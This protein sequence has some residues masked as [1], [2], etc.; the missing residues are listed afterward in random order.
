MINRLGEL[1]LDSTLLSVLCRQ[2]EMLLEMGP[3]S[4][5]GCGIHSESSPVHAFAKFLFLAILP[6]NPDLAFMVGKKSLRLPILDDN[7]DPEEKESNAAA[8]VMSRF[9]R[10]FTLGHIENQQCFLAST[11][12]IAAKDNP[13]Q[14]NEPSETTRSVHLRPRSS[15]RPSFPVDLLCQ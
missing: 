1:H 8:L 2:T 14:L 9:P 15:R 3:S 12:I 10:W 4:A 5:L 13:N 11:L 6:H 7:K